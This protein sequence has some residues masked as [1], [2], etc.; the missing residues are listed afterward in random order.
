[1][2][3]SS[4][5]PGSRLGNEGGL[6]GPSAGL[7]LGRDH[8]PGCIPRH[9]LQTRLPALRP[10]WLRKEQFYV[11]KLQRL[12]TLKLVMGLVGLERGI[13]VANRDQDKHETWGL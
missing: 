7:I 2:L 4:R 12:L 5:P 10:P 9:S 8:Q 3:R 13:N 1:M 11:S 6:L